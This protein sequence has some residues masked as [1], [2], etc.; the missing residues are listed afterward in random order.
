MSENPELQKRIAKLNG[1]INLNN[2][3]NSG[4]TFP[5]IRLQDHQVPEK[6]AQLNS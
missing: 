6:P 2:T 5:T 4:Q 1:I 3:A